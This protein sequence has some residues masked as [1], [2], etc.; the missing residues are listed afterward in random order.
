MEEGADNLSQRHQFQ[1]ILPSMALMLNNTTLPLTMGLSVASSWC[2]SCFLAT[3]HSG[4]QLVIFRQQPRDC[5]G[6]RIASITEFVHWPR[7]GKVQESKQFVTVNVPPSHSADE[8]TGKENLPPEQVF[9]L[10][11]VA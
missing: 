10:I 8:D 5:V 9:Y 4:F 6:I 3:W 1:G 11:E 7:T 2:A